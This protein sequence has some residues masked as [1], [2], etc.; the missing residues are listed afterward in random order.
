MDRQESEYHSM[1]DTMVRLEEAGSAPAPSM[2][3]AESQTQP[4]AT[5]L[6]ESRN[7]MLALLLESRGAMWDSMDDI[8]A[9]IGDLR[10]FGGGPIHDGLEDASGAARRRNGD[11]LA[12]ACRKF[13]NLWHGNEEGRLA[14]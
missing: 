12:S 2:P 11:R 3:L 8:E 6:A 7:A 4:G 10:R 14:A 9:A 5:A 1:K 13:L